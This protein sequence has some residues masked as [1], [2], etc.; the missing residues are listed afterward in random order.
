MSDFQYDTLI[1]FSNP[2]IW[3]SAIVR[4]K[5]G[6]IDLY[7]HREHR[8]NRRFIGRYSN[9]LSLWDVRKMLKEK[10]PE[11]YEDEGAE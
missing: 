6:A 2:D 5:L 1:D 8:H 10:Y 7:E 3:F 9:N 4:P 11:L